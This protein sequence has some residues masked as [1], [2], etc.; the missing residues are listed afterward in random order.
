MSENINK[1]I[2]FNSR[3]NIEHF[4]D[5]FKNQAQIYKS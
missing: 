1:K 2:F 4:S 3:K 5:F